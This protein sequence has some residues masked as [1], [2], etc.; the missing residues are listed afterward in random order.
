MTQVFQDQVALVTGAAGGIGQAILQTLAAEGARLAAVDLAEAKPAGA[1]ADLPAHAGP[2]L[3]YGFDLSITRE[4]P[5][6]VDRILQ[7]VGQIDLLI[8]NAAVV[9]R[10]SLFEITEEDWD[11]V[12]AINLKAPFLLTQTV[13]HQ[14]VNR[15]AGG[16]VVNVASIAGQIARADKAHY[17]SSKAALIHFTRCAAMELGPHGIRVNVICPGPTDTPMIAGSVDQAYIQRHEITLGRVASPEDQAKAVRF[18]LGPE[19]SHITGQVL[20]VDGGELKS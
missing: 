19:S 1:I 14:L 16:V 15:G 18:L 6:L 7:D 17:A 11:R 8:N 10:T 12:F 2:H 3:A 13:S 9:Q 20:T 5:Q 4:I